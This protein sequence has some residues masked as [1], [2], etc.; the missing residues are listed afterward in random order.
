MKS[1]KRDS[2]GELVMTEYDQPFTPVTLAKSPIITETNMPKLAE[3]KSAKISDLSASLLTEEALME[4]MRKAGGKN[5]HTSQFATMI[6]PRVKKSEDLY[7]HDL[8]DLA[9]GY[10]RTL[11]RS[12]AKQGKVTMT[13]DASTK[14]ILYVYN[15]V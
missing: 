14:R 9:H 6:Y 8:W 4:E 1:L 7:R 10:I 11:M 5:L 13:R 12:L 15:L 2:N 3:H